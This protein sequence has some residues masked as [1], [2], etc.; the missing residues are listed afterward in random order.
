[1]TNTTTA[2][3]NAIA[4]ATTNGFT[5]EAVLNEV[6]VTDT[7]HA[8]MVETMFNIVVTNTVRKGVHVTENYLKRMNETF[9]KFLKAT[10]IKYVKSDID[11][12]RTFDE[13]TFIFEA[14]KDEWEENA[15]NLIALLKK[16]RI[17]FDENTEE[18]FICYDESQNSEK[19]LIIVE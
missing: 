2:T 19:D 15:I 16:E 11:L 4:S 7:M 10:K 3:N 9:E 8:T 12:D 6:S 5:F 14:D 13:K 18:G 17:T 1:M